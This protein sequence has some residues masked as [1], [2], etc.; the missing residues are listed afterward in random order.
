MVRT[1]EVTDDTL[2]VRTLLEALLLVREFFPTL[3]QKPEELSVKRKVCCR[4]ECKKRNLVHTKCPSPQK[5]PEYLLSFLCL[6]FFF[7]VMRSSANSQRDRTEYLRSENHY[8]LLKVGIIRLQSSVF[9][10]KN[11]INEK[12]FE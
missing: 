11:S 3:S 10:P 4:P 2:V 8:L 7:R 6:A 9:V 1:L 12:R 5:F